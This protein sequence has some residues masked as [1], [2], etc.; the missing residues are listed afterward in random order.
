MTNA[1]VVTIDPATR[2]EALTRLM[3]AIGLMHG[4][5]SVDANVTDPVTDHAAATRAKHELQAK[6]WEALI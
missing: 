5:V 2:D 1:L 4:V 6:L 3:D